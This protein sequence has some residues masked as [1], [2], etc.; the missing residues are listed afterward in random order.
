[1]A[2]AI[3][4][5]APCISEGTSLDSRLEVL[6]TSFSEWKRMPEG[7]RLHYGKLDRETFGLTSLQVPPT[8]AWSK[9]NDT[10]VLLKFMEYFMKTMTEKF[11]ATPITNKIF[12]A[13]VQIN[14]AFGIMYRGGVWLSSEEA[15]GAG[16]AGLAFL[17]CYAQLASSTLS[18]GRCRFAYTPKCH[19]IHHAFLSMY[20][21]ADKYTWSVNPV[22]YSVQIDEDF[23][24]K[25]SRHARRVGHVKQMER[26][27]GRYRLGAK[28]A[29][30]GDEI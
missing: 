21:N 26:T 3:A 30:D 8:A 15:R 4:E 27:I 12:Q 29:M 20:R 24:G 18:A 11:V 5:L 2:S 1:M 10:R 7:M 16:E 9:F 25:I 6:Q 28:L 23:V 22:A 19:Y 13:I 17:T 14:I